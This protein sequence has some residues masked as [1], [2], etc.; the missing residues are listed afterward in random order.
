MVLTKYPATIFCW[1]LRME[2]GMR[3][4][5][6]ASTWAIL[7]SQKKSINLWRW[8]KKPQCLCQSFSGQVGA[9]GGCFFGVERLFMV[10]IWIFR[11]RNGKKCP[12]PFAKVRN[13]A[14]PLSR[15]DGVLCTQRTWFWGILTT[16]QREKRKESYQ[17]DRIL[18][19]YVG[20]WKHS[21]YLQTYNPI[22]PRFF[23]MWIPWV[24]LFGVTSVRISSARFCWSTDHQ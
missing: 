22:R 20:W 15:F 17:D 12:C 8:W 19:M 14:N 11:K 13:P 2:S 16:F 21:D 4:E 6:Q 3:E 10:P 1:I 7:D 18:G 24:W 23:D 9:P 5:R